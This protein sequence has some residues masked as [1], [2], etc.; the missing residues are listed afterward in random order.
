MNKN[1]ITMDFRPGNTRRSSSQRDIKAFTQS[2]SC[3]DFGFDLD[4]GDLEAMA[5]E[6]EMEAQERITSS[7]SSL[8]GDG[9][10]QAQDMSAAK[11]RDAFFDDMLEP[12]ND[13]GES[14][15]GVPKSHSPQ[16]PSGDT[17]LI[18]GK[19]KSKRWEPTK[20]VEDEEEGESNRQ[21][22]GG[23]NPRGLEISGGE[24][25]HQSSEIGR[26]HNGASSNDAG[27]GHATI[28]KDCIERAPTSR[29][30]N[31][32]EGLVLASQPSSSAPNSAIHI[33]APN[34]TIN[35]IIEQKV[36]NS[37]TVPSTTRGV[38]DMSV[39]ASAKDPS[40]DS[41]HGNPSLDASEKS[42]T[43]SAARAREEGSAIQGGD[44]NTQQSMSKQIEQSDVSEYVSPVPPAI[45]KGYSLPN[46][47]AFVEND[48][49]DCASSVTHSM[50]A[51]LTTAENSSRH[52]PDRS[53]SEGSGPKSSTASARAQ[54]YDLA[55]LLNSLCEPDKQPL[56][57]AVMS[58]RSRSSSESSGSGIYTAGVTSFY[59][60]DG[61]AEGKQTKEMRKVP[62]TSQSDSRQHQTHQTGTAEK[63]SSLIGGKGETAGIINKQERKTSKPSLT[64]QRKGRHEIRASSKVSEDNRVNSSTRARSLSRGKSRNPK[65]IRPSVH[66]EEEEPKLGDFERKLAEAGQLNYQPKSRA[67]CASKSMPSNFKEDT[68]ESEDEET[69]SD[70]FE[71]DEGESSDSDSF[72]PGEDEKC[73]PHEEDRRVSWSSKPPKKHSMR[74]LYAT[75]RLESE[76]SLSVYESDSVSTDKDFSS[77]PQPKRSSEG[78]N[79]SAIAE[80]DDRT[81]ATVT[82]S[83]PSSKVDA[84]MS[85][86]A[87]NFV[88]Q[89]S[90]QE[91]D[92]K[93]Q[94]EEIARRLSI[95]RLAK[96]A[97]ENENDR[98]S[99]CEGNIRGASTSLNDGSKQARRQSAEKACLR[100]QS[101]K[102]Q[103]DRQPRALKERSKS[104]KMGQHQRSL[105]ADLQA[106]SRS[107]SVRYPASNHV[108]ER[109]FASHRGRRKS[110][111]NNGIKRSVTKK[112]SIGDNLQSEDDVIHD[113]DVEKLFRLEPFDNAFVRRSGGNWTYA[114]VVEVTATEIRFVLDKAGSKKRCDRSSLLH[115]IRRLNYA[116]CFR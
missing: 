20:I 60:R 38:N 78:S 52:A 111:S 107:K 115:N 1:H 42:K 54:P 49:N 46:H 21:D 90:K 108:D 80:G 66:K 5:M 71:S 3:G 116:E 35:Y 59:S 76:R 62:P 51:S 15:G 70:P 61:K 112:Y 82:S 31:S 18:P 87:R 101:I 44:E 14:E 104:M 30:I 27:Q 9:I 58:V 57:A 86:F 47:L 98:L 106:M 72:E 69:D 64:S 96:P 2:F 110:N 105:D 74:D 50:T 91:E 33:N 75:L 65:E 77:P 12:E 92:K 94:K 17:K 100:S 19:G 37:E 22:R 83:L 88:D 114:I 26:Q 48:F 39:D 79:M 29:V 73:M 113:T 24:A 102:V 93:K 67:A 13:E 109:K 85:E 41:H 97:R 55:E 25:S 8:H 43:G 99:K 7:L 84:E 103:D 53:V 16:R 10:Q 95:D 4:E 36:V 68:S 40:L 32:D 56:Q 6:A 23:S 11:G 89:F 28:G 34:V 45:Q 63:R 81:S